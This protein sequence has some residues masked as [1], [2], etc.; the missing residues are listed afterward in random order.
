ML[1]L[2]QQK[3]LRCFGYIA[4]ATSAIWAVQNLFE[5]VQGNENKIWRNDF[6]LKSHAR[7]LHKIQD[8]LDKIQDG[9]E[10]KK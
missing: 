7:L 3:Y 10:F 2:S 4:A 1:T 9:L 8:D 5:T 6:H